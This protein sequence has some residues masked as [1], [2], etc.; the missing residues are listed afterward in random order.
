MIAFE[1]QT[2]FLMCGADFCHHAFF[3]FPENL[4]RRFLY[5]KSET[6]KINFHEKNDFIREEFSLGIMTM[7]KTKNPTKTP[8]LWGFLFI[9]IYLIFSFLGI[10][11]K[12]PAAIRPVQTS[13]SLPQP[14]TGAAVAKRVFEIPAAT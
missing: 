14:Q 12:I 2:S 5:Y 10:A 4:E 6:N 1:V 7:P 3:N 9:A 13:I 11:S 8:F